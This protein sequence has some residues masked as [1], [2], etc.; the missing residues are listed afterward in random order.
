M[1]S[2]GVSAHWTLD[3][4]PGLRQ[5][6]PLTIAAVLLRDFSR[7]RDDATVVVAKRFS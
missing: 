7:G 1:H 3:A 6:D 5:H 4:Y 2:D